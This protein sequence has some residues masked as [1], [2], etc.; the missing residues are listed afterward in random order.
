MATHPTGASMDI[1]I[2]ER[3]DQG[4]SC[5]EHEICDSVLSADLLAL[6]EGVVLRA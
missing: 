2:I 4:H 3:G 1:L 6:A 5:R